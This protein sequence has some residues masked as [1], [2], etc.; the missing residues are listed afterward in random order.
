MV[1]IEP[2]GKAD[3][4]RIVKGRVR[5]AAFGV[6]YVL[7][8]TYGPQLNLRGQGA[9]LCR[10]PER[11]KLRSLPRTPTPHGSPPADASALGAAEACSLLERSSGLVS[12]FAEIIAHG[13]TSLQQCGNRARAAIRSRN[14]WYSAVAMA[15]V[16]KA[17]M[18]LPV[19]RQR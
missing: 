10:C 8:D 15:I 6:K 17:V 3:G 9:S 1:V 18:L 19:G 5:S 12:V 11:D 16:F 7:R 13:V 2:R 4:Q 14:R